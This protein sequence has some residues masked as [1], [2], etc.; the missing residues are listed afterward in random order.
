MSPVRGVIFDG[1][2][3]VF[4]SEKITNEGFRRILRGRGVDLTPEET[5][6][7]IGIGPPMLLDLVAE[8]YGVRFDHAEYNV[9]RD[10]VF[11]E[12]CLELDAPA[13]IPG[14][15]DLLDWLGT[16]GIPFGLATGASGRKMR[17]NLARTG[18]AERFAVAVCGSDPPRPKPF[19]DIYIYT[20]ERLAV[21][22][23]E[24]LV[25]EDSLPG[26]RGAKESGAI[27]AAIEGSHERDLLLA[28]TPF[29]F[30]DH[31]AVRA[32]LEDGVFDRVPVA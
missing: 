16:N 6:A 25:L 12:M 8:K 31:F 32:A 23:E 20:A 22:V 9:L 13:V 19:P 10:E 11:E 30:P 2:G 27:A 28:E 7:F 29:V 26:I 14:I 4:D 1:D 15:H 3:V 17:F 5:E 18:L 24:C 21:P